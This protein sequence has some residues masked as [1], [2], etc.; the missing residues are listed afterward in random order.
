MNRRIKITRRMAVVVTAIAAVATALT[1]MLTATPSAAAHTTATRSTATSV[2]KC[3]AADLGV[4]VAADLTGAA[5]GTLYMPIE[6]T[7]LSRHAC[8]LYGFP[9]VSAL[10]SSGQQLGSPAAWD[11]LAKLSLVRLAPGGTAYA[12]LEYSDVVTGNCPSAGKRLAVELRVY[13]PDQSRADHAYWP[14]T[15]CVAKGQTHFIR[16]RA[17]GP[18]FGA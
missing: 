4:W 9:G 18:G 8:T 16:V 12:L 10:G 11:R 2:P 17:I 7:N 6:F 1:L 3:S 14:F 5:A 15:A 13:P